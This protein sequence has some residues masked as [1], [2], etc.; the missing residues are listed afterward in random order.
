M[1]VGKKL[2][3]LLERTGLGAELR[4]QAEQERARRVTAARAAKRQAQAEFLRARDT[5]QPKLNAAERKQ[6]DARKAAEAALQDWITLRQ[7]FSDVHEVEWAARQKAD[8]ELIA[9]ANPEF[10]VLVADLERMRDALGEEQRLVKSSDGF[11]KLQPRMQR[12]QALIEEAQRLKLDPD[13]D[14]EPAA[15]ARIRKTAKGV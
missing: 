13:I 10:D 7:Q 9:N 14:D 2:A 1:D 4:D 12:L 8:A 6:E 11:A 3:L 5:L 15:I